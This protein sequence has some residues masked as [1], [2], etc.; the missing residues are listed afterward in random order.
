L[1]ADALRA[2]WLAEGTKLAAYKMPSQVF[3]W[4]EDQLPRGATGKIPKKEI[5]SRLLAPRSKL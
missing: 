5:R 1:T 3:I 2:F 4:P